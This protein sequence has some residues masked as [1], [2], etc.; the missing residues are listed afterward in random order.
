[1]IDRNYTLQRLKSRRTTIE[2]F[3]YDNLSAPPILS[4][5][6]VEDIQQLNSIATSIRYSAKLKEKYEA[7]DKIMVSRGFKKL[8]SGTNRVTYEPVFATNFVVKV[9]YDSVALN[10]SIREYHNQF[11]LKP[12]CTKVFE[13]SPCGTLGVFERVNPITSRKEYISMAV[14]IYKLLSEF[15]IGKYIID[16]IGTN[17]FNNIGFRYGFGAV[18]LDFPYVYEVDGKKLWCNKPNHNDP[19]GYCNGEID[20]DLGFNKLECKKCGAI[21][22]PFELAVKKM[23]YNKENY[24]PIIENEEDTNMK[25]RFHGGSLGDGVCQEKVTG[26][27]QNPVN[28]IISDAIARK[29]EKKAKEEEAKK[30]KEALTVNGVEEPEA[31]VVQ[32][33]IDMTPPEKEE[34]KEVMSPFSIDENDIGK[35]DLGYINEDEDKV[36]KLLSEIINNYYFEDTKDEDKKKIAKACCE[37]L[38]DIFVENIEEVVS[39]FADVLRKKKNIKDEIIKGFLDKNSCSINNQFIKLLLLSEDYQIKV[40]Y[41]KMF[42]DN[43]D[44]TVGFKFKPSIIKNGVDKPIAVGEDQDIYMPSLELYNI[45]KDNIDTETEVNPENSSKESEGIKLVDAVVLSRKDI[46]TSEKNLKCVAI[47]NDD[48]TYLTINGSVICIDKIDDVNVEDIEFVSSEW[49]NNAV[50]TIE[51]IKEPPVGSL[52]EDYDDEEDSGEEE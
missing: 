11:L 43:K 15:I 9:A 38:K 19:T 26:E 30:E 29:A 52:P 44:D 32:E 21:Y 22:K 6:T 5:F 12:F 14:D 46:F 25:I 51:N 20:Y 41:Q 49:Y 40:N 23:S 4:M 35:G 50:E 7:I 3:N 36:T 16:D 45:I 37:M 2:E 31:P 27:F 47:K 24:S 10:D 48:N 1:M 34:E 39:M 17:Y 28:C 18:V 33:E 8:V 42:F 13:V